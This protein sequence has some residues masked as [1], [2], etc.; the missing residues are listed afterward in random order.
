[1]DKMAYGKRENKKSKLPRG[2]KITG[3]IAGGIIAF[4]ILIAV[5][6]STP[7]GGR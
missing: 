1:M 2:L 3:W 6:I 4:L 5:L 7:P